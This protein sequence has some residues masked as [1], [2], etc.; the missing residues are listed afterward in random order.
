M[1]EYELPL[2]VKQFIERLEELDAGERARLKRNAGRTLAESRNVL[3]LFYRLL[4]PG[5]PLYQQEVF[6]LIATLHPLAKGGGQGDLGASL[7]RAR[8]PANA[9]GLDRRVE[10]LLDADESQLPFRLRQ[11]IHFL[12]SNRI[13]V[14]WPRLLDDLLHWGHSGRNVQKRWARSYFAIEFQKQL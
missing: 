4:P 10:V 13:S 9:H 7:H 5:V 1:S 12:Q 14:N 6:F 8:R 3:G 2:Q 11:A